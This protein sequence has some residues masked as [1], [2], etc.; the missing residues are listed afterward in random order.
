MPT[1]RPIFCRLVRPATIAGGAFGSN[2][3]LAEEAPVDVEELMLVDAEGEADCEVLLDLSLVVDAADVDGD[4]D[5]QA[6]SGP[7]CMIK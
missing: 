7:Y 5:G 2:V 4:V 3:E 6:V 1:P